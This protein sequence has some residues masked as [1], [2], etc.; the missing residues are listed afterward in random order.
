[1]H[2][3]IAIISEPDVNVEKERTPPNSPSLRYPGMITPKKNYG[4]SVNIVHYNYI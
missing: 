1:M 3:S 2:F 4:R